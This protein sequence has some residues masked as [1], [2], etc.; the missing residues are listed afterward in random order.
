MS[1][2]EEVEKERSVRDTQHQSDLSENMKYLKVFKQDFDAEPF[3]KENGFSCNFY[4]GP[5]DPVNESELF[6][7]KIEN[8]N[9]K[10]ITVGLY[11][12]V[13]S[14]DGKSYSLNSPRYDSD[15]RYDYKSFTADATNDILKKIIND[16]LDRPELMHS[17][18]LW[19]SY[20]NF[21]KLKWMRAYEEKQIRKKVWLI[22]ACI[23]IVLFILRAIL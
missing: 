20:D 14:L 12:Q 6:I 4:N 19:D 18:D 9:G 13:R 11:T 23:V 7:R 3:F 16:F 5:A 1:I 22:I 2:L 17:N 10:G 8:G 15:H 21:S